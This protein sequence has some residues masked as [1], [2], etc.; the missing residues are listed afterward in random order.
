MSG[1]H[2]ILTMYAE[3]RQMSRP[4][5]KRLE[6]YATI[7]KLAAQDFATFKRLYNKNKKNLPYSYRQ[8]YDEWWDECNTDGSFAYNNASDDF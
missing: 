5:K 7:S 1:V 4:K 3:T 2:K 8:S 6:W